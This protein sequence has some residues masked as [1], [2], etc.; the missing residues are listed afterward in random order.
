MSNAANGR[1]AILWDQDGK[2]GPDDPNT[3]MRILLDWLLVEGNYNRYRGNGGHSKLY[4]C[5]IIA[6][7]IK[8][9]GC[10]FERSDKQVKSKIEHLER[11]FRKARFWATFQTGAG[12]QATDVGT[13]RSVLYSKCAHYD[14]LLPIMAERAG[15]EPQLTNR[16]LACGG[17]GGDGG[18][19]VGAGGIAG[20]IGVAVGAEGGGVVGG[21]V[22]GGGIAGSGSDGGIAGGGNDCEGFAAA[23]ARDDFSDIRGR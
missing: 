22:V 1:R 8:A 14:D 11:Q 12:L 21:G 20:A 15:T 3:S 7:R 18:N 23:A 13:Y 19:G 4:Y 5:R 9:A 2:D 10:V 6:D 17:D 16:D